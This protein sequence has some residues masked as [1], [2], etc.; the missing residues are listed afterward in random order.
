MKIASALAVG[1]LVIGIFA[2]GADRGTAPLLTPDQEQADRLA[3]SL[4]DDPGVKAARDTGLKQWTALPAYQLPGAPELLPAAI[5]EAEFMALRAVAAGDAG[6]PKVVW[7]ASPAYGFGDIKVP[8]TRFAGDNPDRIYRTFPVESS[9]R[10]EIHGRRRKAASNPDF[11]FEAIASSSVG[12]P[13]ASLKAQDIDVAPDGSFTIT[14][15]STPGNGSRNHLTLSP[16]TR[17]VLVRDTLADWSTQLPNEVSVKRVDVLPVQTRSSEQIRKQAA[18]EVA[19]VLDSNVHFLGMVYNAPVNRPVAHVRKPEDGVAGAI[20][21]SSRFSI[22]KD[23]ALVVTLDPQGARYVGFQLTDPWFRSV[24]YWNATGSL[25]DRQAKPNAD[26]SFTYIISARDPG[27][28]NWL[29]TG[30]LTD[31]ILLVRVENFHQVPDPDKVFRDVQLVKVTELAKALPQDALR[32]TPAER[33]KQLSLRAAGY[34]RRVA[35]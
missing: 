9:H 11:L 5:D 6:S 22:A 26:G 13:T 35:S 34:H 21:G 18:A 29:S 31:G 10:Y 8:G 3:L 30:G 28:H 20:A 16:Q 17:Y 33:A 1:T 12:Q 27:Y 24:P 2:V 14:L 19:A 15:D 7:E 23:E 32:V 25:S 4:L